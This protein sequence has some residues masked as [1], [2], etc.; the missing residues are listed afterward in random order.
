VRASRLRAGRRARRHLRRLLLI[1]IAT[2]Y[3]VGAVW[4]AIVLMWHAQAKSAQ[5]T[6][7][8]EQTDAQARPSVRGTTFPS[9][10]PSSGTPVPP[11]SVETATALTDLRG[12]GLVLPVQ[13][14]RV[15]DLRNTFRDSR[16]NRAHE[17]IDILAPRGT[18]VLAVDDG[19]IARLFLSHAGGI[20]IYHFDSDERYA[21]YYA[22]LERYA[23]GLDEGDHVRRGQVIGYVGT[24][25]N[26]PPGT[27]HL[28][29]GIFQLG[30][31]KHWWEGTPINPYLVWR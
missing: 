19:R 9:A 16:G 23:D 14:I 8:T 2:V 5:S 13:G 12:R 31:E 27:P 4:L 25:G 3:S 18:S 24:T 11:V 28:H 10:S 30:P 1:V 29:F 17:A 22:H 7:T 26:A 6:R 20:T 15:A 21:Y